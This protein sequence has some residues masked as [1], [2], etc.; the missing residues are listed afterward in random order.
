MALFL[1]DD[2]NDHERIHVPHA[3]V[4]PFTL[5]TFN[6]NTTL[7]IEGHMLEL[8]KFFEDVQK[9]DQEVQP[10]LSDSLDLKNKFHRYIDCT[11]E[12][13][14]PCEADMCE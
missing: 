4:E 8:S 12:E 1:H 5:D 14:E 9:F 11:I 2:D 10:F 3:N 7:Q 6:P 13:L